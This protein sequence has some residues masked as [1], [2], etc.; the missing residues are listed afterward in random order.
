MT[1]DIVRP[2]GVEIEV[3]A[4]ALGHLRDYLA[5][6]PG[7][8]QVRL[9]AGEDADGALLVIPRPAAE[10]LADVLSHFAS[11]EGVAVMSSRTELTTQQA[12]DLLNVS[13][14]YLIGLL[15]AGDIEYR[16]VGSHRRVVV[17]SLMDYRARAEATRRQAADELSAATQDLNLTG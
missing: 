12:A 2:N 1:V 3:A 5:R 6:H 4:D 8:E 14:P 11:G 15:N 10:L 13:R 17:G 16:M 7:T 9:R